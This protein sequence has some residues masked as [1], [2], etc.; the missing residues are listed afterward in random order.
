[1]TAFV[2]VG[3][4]VLGVVEVGLLVSVVAVLGLAFLLLVTGL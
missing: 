2:L 1:M 4:E 3:P